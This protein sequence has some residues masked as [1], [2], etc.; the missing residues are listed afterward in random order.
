MYKP[1]WS[2]FHATQLDSWLQSEKVDTV[3]VA[4]CNYPNC[5]GHALRCQ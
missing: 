2:A 1:R 4:G 3:V 5:P